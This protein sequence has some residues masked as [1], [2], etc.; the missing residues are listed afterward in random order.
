MEFIRA[1]KALPN[2]R[3]HRYKLEQLRELIELYE[4][5]IAELWKEFVNIGGYP[6]MVLKP[7]IRQRLYSSLFSSYLERDVG[8]LI[9]TGNYT[10][11]QDFLRILSEEGGKIYNRNSISRVLGRD[12]R[13]IRK[14]EEILLATFVTYKL[15]PFYTNIRKEIRKAPR[16]YFIDT[17]I[18]NYIAKDRK[19]TSISGPVLEN[20]LIS[21]I[22]RILSLSECSHHWWRTKGGAEVDFII[23]Y[24]N[25][26]I[27]VEIK[28]G[29]Y[30]KPKLTR[31]FISFLKYYHPSRAFFITSSLFKKDNFNKTEV[32]YIPSY[33]FPLLEEKELIPK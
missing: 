19:D 18:R 30:K 24:K 32:W 2:G 29:I 11:F 16:F 22:I 7:E 27:P 21:E 8:N 12:I 3:I 17:G 31:S 5:R 15:T 14:F 28:K 13:T 9:R 26:V 4:N 6:E 33:I 20:L 25:K 23:Q 1:K 10:V